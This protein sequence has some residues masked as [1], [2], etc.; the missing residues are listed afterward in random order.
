MNHRVVFINIGV[1]V[2]PKRRLWKKPAVMMVNINIT[3]D[4]VPTFPELMETA[5]DELLKME[6]EEVPWSQMELRFDE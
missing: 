6:E 3:A 2:P 1:E 5:T 4:Y